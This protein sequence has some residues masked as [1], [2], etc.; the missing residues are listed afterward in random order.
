MHENIEWNECEGYIYPGKFI[1]PDNILNNMFSKIGED[2]D[3]YEVE[4]LDIYDA[5][6]T[7]ISKGF[8][9]GNYKKTGKKM[10]SLFAHFWTFENG[11]LI[12]FQQVCDTVKVMETIR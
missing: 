1:G 5:G 3:N 11:K 7:I 10:H 6:S 4:L 8:Y 9:N 2:W 12:H